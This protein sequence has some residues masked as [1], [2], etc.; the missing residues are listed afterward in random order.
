MAALH[1]RVDVRVDDHERKMDAFGIL[2]QDLSTFEE[3]VFEMNMMETQFDV[4]DLFIYI[5]LFDSGFFKGMKENPGLLEFFN[6]PFDWN[7]LEKLKP[8]WRL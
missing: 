1:K 3:L 7:E 4:L 5:Y 6:L 2:F 8:D